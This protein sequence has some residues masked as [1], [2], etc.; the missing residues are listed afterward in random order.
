MKRSV[1]FSFAFSY[2]IKLW[3]FTNLANKILRIKT[4]LVI[5]QNNCTISKSSCTDLTT[6]VRIV[7]FMVCSLAGEGLVTCAINS[8]CFFHSLTSPSRVLS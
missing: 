6:H 8:L 1:V 7:T 3:D 2:H 5:F 4:F